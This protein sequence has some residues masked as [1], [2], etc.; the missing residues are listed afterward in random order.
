MHHRAESLA[1]VETI[2]D[3]GISSEAREASLNPGVTGN[4]LGFGDEEPTQQCSGPTRP[5][6]PPPA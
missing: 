5:V 2:L 6:A 4:D 3:V 1:V